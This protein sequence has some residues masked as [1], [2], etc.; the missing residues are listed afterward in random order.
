MSIL[1]FLLVML[2]MIDH[3]LKYRP[4]RLIFYKNN[5]KYSVIIALLEEPPHLD[6]LIEL[7]HK[8]NHE[9]LFVN[10]NQAID[11]SLYEEIKIIDLDLDERTHPSTVPILNK[12]YLKGYEH[13]N[14]NFLLFMN[15]ALRFNESKFLTHMANNLVEHQLYTVKESLPKR[16]N[17]EGYKLFFDLFDDI[18]T[19]SDHIN[20]NFFSIKRSTFELADCHEELFEDVESFE[21]RL[22]LRNISVLYI[23]HNGSVDRV[24][25]HRLFKPYIREWFAL[26]NHKANHSGLRRMLL[27][28][29]VFH[30]FYVFIVIDFRVVTLI[31]I[32]LVHAA[33]YLVIGQRARHG[34]LAFL[35]LPFYMLM[36]D[37]VLLTAV[38]K[39]LLFQ[40]KQSKKHA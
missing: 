8:N 11:A 9:F 3:A 14:N 10:V 4:H 7:A 25:R 6:E 5:H 2:V 26:Y 18:E 40:R 29:L 1:S 34:F 12:A 19:T 35:L 23:I 20:Y 36:F 28:L 21:K 33:F 16:T 17:K 30:V 39:R 22:H 38:F 37:A 24:E 31:F 15:G 27:F 32:P 13:A